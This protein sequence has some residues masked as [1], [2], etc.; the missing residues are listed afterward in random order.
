METRVGER[1]R[2]RVDERG[3]GADGTEKERHERRRGMVSECCFTTRRE[4]A[5]VHAWRFNDENKTGWKINVRRA[6]VEREEKSLSYNEGTEGFAP[7][8]CF[9]SDSPSMNS[10]A[11]LETSYLRIFREQKPDDARARAEK[12]EREREREKVESWRAAK[13]KRGRWRYELTSE[14]V[15]TSGCL[16]LRIKSSRS[17]RNLWKIVKTRSFASLSLS[18]SLSFLSLSFFFRVFFSSFFSFLFFHY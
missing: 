3:S 14:I 15:W 18:L 13:W 9:A 16:L 11:R 12:K 7:A 1:E 2:E 10:F 4:R 17:A 6:E 8:F 5:R